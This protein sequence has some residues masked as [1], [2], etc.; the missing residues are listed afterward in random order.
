MKS[1]RGFVLGLAL[2]F[3][4]SSCA[5]VVASLPKVI[6]VVTDASL[7]LDQINT[8]V[9][10]VFAAADA[11]G[12]PETDL[13]KKF[14]EAITKARS[15][16]AAANR[17][18]AGAENLSQSQIAEAFADFR[19]AYQDLL[20]LVGPLGVSTGNGNGDKAASSGPSLQVPEPLALTL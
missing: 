14:N 17:T 8:F 20:A 13:Q 2:V 19:A 4:V 5:A 1:L 9:N 12:K 18:A 7:I 10:G 15:A 3:S 6:A 16:L 11:A